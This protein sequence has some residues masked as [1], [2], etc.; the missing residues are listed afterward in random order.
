MEFKAKGYQI[1]STFKLRNKYATQIKLVIDGMEKRYLDI[2]RNNESLKTALVELIR[3][4]YNPR[5]LD[6]VDKMNK[7]AIILGAQ[8][9]ADQLNLIINKTVFARLTDD[10]FEKRV[11]ELGKIE[12]MGNT[13][14]DLLENKAQELFDLKLMPADISARIKDEFP[15]LADWKADQIAET[16]ISRAADFAGTQMVK[17][18]GLDVEAWF[19]VDPESCDVCQ[20]LASGNPYTLEEAELMGLPHPNCRDQWSFTLKGEE[21]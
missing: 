20:E 1:A 21:A 12:N 15:D 16:E 6:L 10:Y 2:I 4:E 17:E 8:S 11:Y 7:D 5:M 3:K 14:R 18:S 19:L 13:L 9:M